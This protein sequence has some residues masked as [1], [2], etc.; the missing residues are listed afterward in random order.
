MAEVPFECRRLLDELKRRIEL[1]HEIEDTLLK[2]GIRLRAFWADL[3]RALLTDAI[4][5]KEAA[6]FIHMYRDFKDAIRWI[7]YVFMRRWTRAK[8]H[9]YLEQLT[10]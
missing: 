4:T 5:D 10:M 7:R 9:E 3:R 1:I 6:E 8:C 2:H